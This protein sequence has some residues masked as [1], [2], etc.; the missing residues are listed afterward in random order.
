MP[1]A[2]L[3]GFRFAS[4]KTDPKRLLEAGYG[5][6]TPS[7]GA[8]TLPWPFGR[9]FFAAMLLALRRLFKRY[10]WSARVRSL[11]SSLPAHFDETQL[12]AYLDG[13]LTRSKRE[14]VS[15]HLRSCWTCRG[16][17]RERRVGIEVFLATRNTR[18]PCISSVS[19]QRIEELRQRLLQVTEAGTPGSDPADPPAYASTGVSVTNGN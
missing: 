11:P 5:N 15:N 7:F 4:N 14:E 6:R 2:R 18:L 12:L 3:L 8:V 19:E 9:G 17:L 13:E 10:V 16:R 1:P